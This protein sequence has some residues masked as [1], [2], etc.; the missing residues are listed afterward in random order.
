M[1]WKTCSALESRHHH[2]ADRNS[3]SLDQSLVAQ[4]IVF[5]L[6]ANFGVCF[7]IILF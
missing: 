7:S 6:V 4:A 3:P 2:R 1:A 5:R